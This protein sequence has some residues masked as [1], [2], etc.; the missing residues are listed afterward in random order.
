VDRLLARVH[1]GD[2]VADAAVVLEVGPLAA[3]ALV[4]QLDPQALRQEGHLAEALA[5]RLEREVRLLEDASVGQE[6]DRRAGLGRLLG[7]LELGH[8]LAPL[9]ALA[10]DV[11]IALDLEQQLLGERVHDRDADTVQAAGNLVAAAAELAAGVQ[12]RH[13]DLRSR[14]PELRHNGHGDA[15]AVV[16]DRYT[17]VGSEVD[18]DVIAAA[19]QG[20]VDAVVHH[21]VDQVVKTARARGA[22][23]H[24]G[25]AAY[26]LEALENGDVF[27]VVTRF[28]QT[29][30]A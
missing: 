29:K 22:D 14:Q 28:S 1:E 10:P 4:D 23:V 18:P 9:V 20:F 12:L 24:A 21:L 11:A 25:P 27:G 5:E 13:H 26:G 3:G 15:A 16:R 17:A 30:P 6:R 8:R 19:L 2:E 7:L